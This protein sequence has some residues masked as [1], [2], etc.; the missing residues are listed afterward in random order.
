[1]FIKV[2]WRFLKIGKNFEKVC[3]FFNNVL[4]KYVAH[5]YNSIIYFPYGPSDTVC[6]LH[7]GTIILLAEHPEGLPDG[8]YEKS[9]YAN[10]RQPNHNRFSDVLFRRKGY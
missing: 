1:M 2:L 3:Y 7:T 6:G 8:G 5:A 9:K 4:D 10:K